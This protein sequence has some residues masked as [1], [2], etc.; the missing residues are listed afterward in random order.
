[1]KV[2]AHCIWPVRLCCTEHGVLYVHLQDINMHLHCTMYAAYCRAIPASCRSLFL[3]VRLRAAAGK[4]SKDWNFQGQCKGPYCLRLFFFFFF[5]RIVRKNFHAASIR[6]CLTGRALLTVAES[7]RACLPS[8]FA[9]HS[10]CRLFCGGH[11]VGKL[12]TTMCSISALDSAA[13]VVH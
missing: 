13:V 12:A 10:V 11:C 8:F 5:R 1:M 3:R 7:T 4:K 9:L 2:P 6:L